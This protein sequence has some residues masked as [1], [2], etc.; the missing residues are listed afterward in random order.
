M[1]PLEEIVS[2]GHLK[3]QIGIP[4][5]TSYDLSLMLNVCQAFKLKIP[6]CIKLLPEHRI[7][8][9]IKWT[10]KPDESHMNCEIH[11]HKLTINVNAYANVSHLN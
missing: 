10:W 4:E 9:D 1:L 5:R 7:V 3:K 2:F 11:C 6:R 8:L